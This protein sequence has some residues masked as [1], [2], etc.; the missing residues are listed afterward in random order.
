MRPPRQ[1]ALEQE[2]P[3]GAPAQSVRGADAVDQDRARHLRSNLHSHQLVPFNRHR[4]SNAI[5]MR[6]TSHQRHHHADSASRFDQIYGRGSPW[7]CQHN[8]HPKAAST[9]PQPTQQAPSSTKPRA[10]RPLLLKG[11]PAL[12]DASAPLTIVE[13][14]DFECSYCRRFHE[15]VMPQLTS[16]YI[17]TGLVRIHKDLPLP[18]HPHAMPAAAAARCAG[19]QNRYW[20]LYSSLF[21]QQTA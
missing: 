5:S 18:F 19:E 16:K 6:D 7:N 14:S 10:H 4:L 3:W 1:E 8:W 12:G 9:A 11:E 17:D 21:D 20:V 15:Q 13:F 2:Q